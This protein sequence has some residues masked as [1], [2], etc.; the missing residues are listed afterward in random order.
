MTKEES[1]L[2]AKLLRSGELDDFTLEAFSIGLQET[3]FKDGYAATE[4]LLARPWQIPRPINAGDVNG[5]IRAFRDEERR[6]QNY[7]G[8]PEPQSSEEQRQKNLQMLREFLAG[9]A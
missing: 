2:I 5:E 7:Q 6:K 8:L 4:R 1:I 9:R 3:D